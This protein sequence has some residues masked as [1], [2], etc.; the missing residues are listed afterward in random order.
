M[1]LVALLIP[2]A[3]FTKI[4]E[5]HPEA[6]AAV[7]NRPGSDGFVNLIQG[8]GGLRGWAGDSSIGPSKMGY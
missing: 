8:R 4:T 2:L 3:A 6:S 5:P 7:T 1:S